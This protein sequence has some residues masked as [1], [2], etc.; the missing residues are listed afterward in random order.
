[1]PL[2]DSPDN[3]L[4]TAHKRAVGEGKDYIHSLASELSASLNRAGI[5]IE[6]DVLERGLEDIA[7]AGGMDIIR[8]PEL[9]KAR[10]EI[11]RILTDN[12]VNP[13]DRYHTILMKTYANAMSGVV[14]SDAHTVRSLA[15]HF[16]LALESEDI[17]INVNVIEKL[18][19]A[20]IE[21]TTEKIAFMKN[22]S[23]IH[24]FLSNPEKL[25]QDLCIRLQLAGL[26]D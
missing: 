11:Q 10:P 6:P 15:Y 12:I 20:G 25:I 4:K 5:N 17:K 18:I 16:S 7:K 2:P 24:E 22:R 9:L 26:L 1:M 19:F 8:D 13:E 3:C 23:A 14:E 21:H